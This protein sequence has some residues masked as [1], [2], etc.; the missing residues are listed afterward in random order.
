CHVHTRFG[1]IQ[2]PDNNIAAV[3]EVISAAAITGAPLHIVHVPSMALG[4]TPIVLR[5]I[6]DAQARGMDLTACCYPYTAFGTGLGSAV[7]DEGW[8]ARFGIDYKDL[9]WV[10]TGER[11]TAE[12]L[13][14]Y[15]KSGGMVIAYAIPEEAVRAA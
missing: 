7:F 9:Q 12:T 5:M 1:A 11:L 2:E 3:E 4:L 13:A 8:Q 6:G 14:K 15:R 10:A